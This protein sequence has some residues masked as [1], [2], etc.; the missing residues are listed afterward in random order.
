M[1]FHGKSLC[2]ALRNKGLPWR[3]ELYR[4]SFFLMAANVANAA[5]GFLFWTAA[6]RLYEPQD[7]GFAA[8][9][10]SG[11]SLVAMLAVLGFD[12]QDA[13]RRTQYAAQS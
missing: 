3:S 6:A 9:I 13:E 5:F 11:V 12:T 8:A 7:V 4:D 2:P 1:P 10:I